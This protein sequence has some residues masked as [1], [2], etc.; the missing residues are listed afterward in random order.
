LEVEDSKL[1]NRVQGYSKLKKRV[2]CY[3]FKDNGKAFTVCGAGFRAK[4]YA[5]SSRF[6]IHDLGYRVKI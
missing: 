3:K 5:H 2:Q 4:G 1:K 6:M